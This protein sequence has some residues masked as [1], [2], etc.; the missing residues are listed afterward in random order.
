MAIEA[1]FYGSNNLMVC[2]NSQPYKHNLQQ[3]GQQQWLHQA[4]Q[5]TQTASLVDPIFSSFSNSN[6]QINAFHKYNH[7]GQPLAS[8]PQRFATQLDEQRE[9]D[10]Y[11]RSQN[12][13]LRVFLQE[14]RKQHM[15]ELLKKTELNALHLLRQKDE[16]IVEATKKTRELKEFLRRLEVEKESWRKVAEENEA[17]VLCLHNNIE[18][19]KE[20]AVHGMTSEDAES[21]CDD[22]VGITASMGEGT[23]E[24]RE[25][26][27]G[28]GEVE[29][30]RKKTMDCKRCNSQKSCFM[31][32]PCRHLCSCKTCEP[33]LQV[34]PVC[35]TPKKSS[36]ETLIV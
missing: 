8:Y 27:G 14:Q 3:P 2:F 17:M 18:R 21:C 30:T 26:H 22:N 20:R 29:E 9:I 31:F 13:K 36:I 19:M 7:N 32:L 28:V 5:M 34:C 10:H 12:E 1:Q 33:F 4:R 35:S 25:R 6:A 24:K 16:E 15:A 23:G 11:I